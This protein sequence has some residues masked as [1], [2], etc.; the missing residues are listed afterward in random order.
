MKKLFIIVTIVL[1]TMCLAGIFVSAKAEQA[2]FTTDDEGIDSNYIIPGSEGKVIINLPKGEVGM[3]V[4]GMVRNLEPNT[5]YYVYL[6]DANLTDAYNSDWYKIDVLW[7]NMFRWGIQV[8]YRFDM[9]TTNEEGHANFHI[10]IDVDDLESGKEP[11]LQ[12]YI[13]IVNSYYKT[14]LVS[15]PI[16]VIIP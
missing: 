11:K 16:E 2:S 5:E 12:V 13:D 6:Y 3:I 10:N 9:I 1:L 8:F 4:Q 14:V 7:D 15:D